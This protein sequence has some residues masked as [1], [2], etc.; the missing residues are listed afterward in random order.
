MYGKVNAFMN[1]VVV[2]LMTKVS[3]PTSKDTITAT[4]VVLI[5][6]VIAGI[7][8]AFFDWLWVL[9]FKWVA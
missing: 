6:V 1:E 2:E 8:L 3:W 7:V 5:T 9:V 4:I